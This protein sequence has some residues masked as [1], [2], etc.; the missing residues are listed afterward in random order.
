MNK[1]R[2][3]YIWEETKIIKYIIIFLGFAFDILDIL[4]IGFVAFTVGT[5]FGI[6][7]ATIMNRFSKEPM[8]DRIINQSRGGGKIRKC[9][10]YACNGSK[11][12]WSDRFGGGSWCVAFDI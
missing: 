7:I 10:D 9:I 2:C 8:V 3:I 6:I 11:C 12:S 4:L 5:A 1:K